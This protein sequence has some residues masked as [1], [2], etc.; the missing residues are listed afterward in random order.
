MS[1]R[2]AKNT[3][4]LFRKMRKISSISF[5]SAVEDKGDLHPVTLFHPFLLLIA[6][7]KVKKKRRVGETQPV[8]SIQLGSE[9]KWGFYF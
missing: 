5:I 1:T 3:K 7:G 4:H 2:D 6:I 9:G 8:W